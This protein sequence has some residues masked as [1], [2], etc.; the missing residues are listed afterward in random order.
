MSVAAAARIG[1]WVVALALLVAPAMGQSAEASSS[2]AGAGEQRLEG[3]FDV[4]NPLSILRAAGEALPVDGRTPFEPNAEAGPSNRGLSATLSILFLLTVLSLA[5]AILIM[6]TCFTRIV[7]TL[8]LLRQAIGTQSVPPSQVI[9]GLS[10][11]LTLLV[12]APTI[13]A[14]NRDAIAPLQ[15]GEIDEVEAWERAKEPIRRFMFDQ[16]AHAGNWDDVYMILRYRGVDTSDPSSLTED[17]VDMLTLV[18]AFIMSELR[19]AFLL[20][21]RLYLPFLV[22]DMVVSSVLISMGMLMLPPILISLPFKLLMF[23]LVDGWRLVVGSLLNGFAVP[24]VTV[25][26]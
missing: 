8:A 7:V 4:S 21:F 20:G 13:D 11:F 25:P 2:V 24:G 10:L 1:L 6:C 19:V 15:A 18:P 9:I 5:P 3:T 17:D 26:L 14:V 16:I 22:I 12:M 23:V